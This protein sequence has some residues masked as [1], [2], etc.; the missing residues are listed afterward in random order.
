MDIR[1]GLAYQLYTKGVSNIDIDP[2]CTIEDPEFFSHRREGVTG[3][4]A[5]VIWLTEQ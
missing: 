1:A 4:Q 3:R 5:G 2:R